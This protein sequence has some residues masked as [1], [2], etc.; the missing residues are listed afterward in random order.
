M[1][2]R[3]MRKGTDMLDAK[4]KASRNNHD[5]FHALLAAAQKHAPLK[6]AVA[7][8]C[9]EASLGSVVEA[10]RLKLIQPI[11]VGPEQRIRAVAAEHG[12]DIAGFEIVDAE[13]SQDSAAKADELV[14]AVVQRETGL[15]TA[16]RISHCFVMDVPGHDQPLVITDAAVN[17]APTLKDKVHIV[18]NA[19]DLAHALGQQDVRV[20]ILSAME[21]VNPDVPSTI[22]AAALC[23]MAD[24][25]QITGAV[26]DGPLALDNAISPQS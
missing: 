14:G 25:G 2:N 23:K 13:Y 19:I 11:L 12:L 20:A 5:K 6:V 24:R 10:A 1:R 3:D 17:I 7:H 22:E 15:R 16:R 26:L 8:P 4:A 21:S 9:D 18:Q